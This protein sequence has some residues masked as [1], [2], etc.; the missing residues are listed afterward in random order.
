MRST[1][2]KGRGLA[3]KEV[4]DSLLEVAF[5]LGLEDWAN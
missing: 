3:A 5:E 2:I 4:R 1:P